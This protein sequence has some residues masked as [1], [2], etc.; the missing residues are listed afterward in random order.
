VDEHRRR[1]LATMT[2]AVRRRFEA[3]L[4]AGC[5]SVLAAACGQGA[6]G[7]HSAS[8]AHHGRET[9]ARPLPAVVNGVP[10][11]EL[12]KRALGAAKAYSVSNPEDVRA[13]LTTQA[14]LYAQ[15]PAAGGAATPEYVVTLGGRFSCGSCGTA[16]AGSTVVPSSAARVSTMV[17]QLPF[18]LA[19]GATTGVAVGAGTPVLAELGHIYDLDPYVRSLAG[20]PVPIGPLPG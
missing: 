12:A 14:A 20:T 2:Y 9:Q 5:V 13:V 1:S 4:A 3:A 6:S 7:S 18:P 15:V 19:P 16:V 10:L 11:L 17:L 8:P